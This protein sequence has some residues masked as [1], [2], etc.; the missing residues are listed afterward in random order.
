VSDQYRKLRNTFRYLLG[1]LDGFDPKVE[2]VEVADMPELERYVLHLLAKLDTKLRV[3]VDDFDFNTYTRLLS[4]FCNEDLSAFFFDIRKDTLYCEVNPASGYQTDKRRAYRTVL[5]VLFHA[6]VRYA[7][8][9]LVFTAEEVWTSRFGADAGSVH[10]AEWPEV[11]AGWC[12]ENLERNWEYLRTARINFNLASEP[13]KSQKVVRSTLEL[14]AEI[15][16]HAEFRSWLEN[17]N[18]EEIL[19]SSS[20]VLAP[21]DNL[22][23]VTIRQPSR[24]E[25]TPIVLQ[26]ASISVSPTTHHKCGRCWRHLP[27]VKTD[28]DL[29]KRCD[30]VLNDGKES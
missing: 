21:N 1:A 27:E 11:D 6:L 14:D 16:V 8:P 4:E 20:A 19:L 17:L 2:G 15:S 10:L 30:T 12:D 22:S 7:A 24:L 13:L 29:C 26:S 28:G 25:A 18:F 3:C 5:D 9:V 23:I